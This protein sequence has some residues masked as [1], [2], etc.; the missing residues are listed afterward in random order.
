[1]P[2]LHS[3]TLCS[4]STTQLEVE[5]GYVPKILRISC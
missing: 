2:A 1:M 3:L 4:L 5:I